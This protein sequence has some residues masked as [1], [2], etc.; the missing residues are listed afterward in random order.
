[1]ALSFPGPDGTGL[2]IDNEVDIR[3]FDNSEIAMRLTTDLKSGDEFVTDLNGF[4][5]IKR[6]RLEK[7]PLQANYYPIPSM[8]YIQVGLEAKQEIIHY[9]TLYYI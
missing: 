7:I 5:M 4:Q 6:K 9:F 2:Q 8:A 1:M 3:H